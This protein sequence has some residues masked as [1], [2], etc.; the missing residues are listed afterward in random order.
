MEGVGEGEGSC[1][2]WG[3]ERQHL[4]LSRVLELE[5]VDGR[6]SGPGARAYMV[7]IF[8]SSFYRLSRE[9]S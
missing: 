9:A 3:G 6:G 4:G 8:S 2:H 5:H 7:T 1:D